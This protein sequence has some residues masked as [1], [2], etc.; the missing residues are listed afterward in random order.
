MGPLLDHLSKL[1]GIQSKGHPG[2]YRSL[3]MA[4]F[5]RMAAIEYTMAHDDGKNPPG[6]DQ[7]DAL[8]LGVSR[9]GKTPLSLYL[10][11]LGWQI[12]NYPLVPEIN[13]PLELTK[14]DPKRVVGLDIEVWQLTQHRKR[15]QEKLGAPGP[16][17]YTDPEAIQVELEEARRLFR[18]NGFK[19]INVTDKPV[20]SSA[21]DVIRLVRRKKR[22][23]SAE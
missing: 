13:P 1:T 23:L 5:E 17:Q 19:V 21:D 8:I 16:T 9:T 22:P 3:N 6:W 12:A 11:V 18:R 15:R 10:S 2:L 4:Y 20:E 14:I 7:A